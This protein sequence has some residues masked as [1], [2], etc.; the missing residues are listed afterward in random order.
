[1]SRQYLNWWQ[2][3]GATH[4]PDRKPKKARNVWAWGDMLVNE[5][6]HY[7]KEKAVAAIG[8]YRTY[9]NYWG[10]K[11]IQMDHKVYADGSVKIRRIA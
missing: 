1:M 8:S 11:V 3:P 4:P 2:V 7:P 9:Q 10:P 6:R 5:K